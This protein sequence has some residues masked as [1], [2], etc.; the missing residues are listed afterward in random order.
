MNPFAADPAFRLEVLVEPPLAL[1]EAS[2]GPVRIVRISGGTISGPIAGTIVPGGTDWQELRADGSVTIEARY[3][4]QL[5]DDARIELQ[6]RGLRNPGAS[7]FWSSIWLRTADPRHDALNRAQ[8]VGWGRKTPQ[9]VA[10]DAWVLPE[11]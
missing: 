7:G 4:L 5:D 2:G 8:F 10:I 3:L 11:R 9:C 1:D 6:S